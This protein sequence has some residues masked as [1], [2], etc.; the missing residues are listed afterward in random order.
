MCDVSDHI[1]SFTK[2]TNQMAI[3]FAI[4][5]FTI[6][7]FAL[8][9]CYVKSSSATRLRSKSR[10]SVQSHGHLRKASQFLSRATST[11]SKSQS[12]TLARNALL[13]AETAVAFSPNDP[14]PLV[15][16]AF[17]LDLLGRKT[18]A[19]R[20]L[21]SALAYRRGRSLA[22]RE[23]GDVLVKRA[24][25][26]IEVNKKRRV[27]SAIEDLKEALEELSGHGNDSAFCLLGE[28]Y[29]WKGMSEE[30]KWA[31]EEALRVNPE[32]VKARQRL[33][34]LHKQN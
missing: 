29:E 14:A 1:N 31:F 12:L 26:K 7:V 25:L 10:T 32:S 2:N 8:Q 4:L 24:E 18:S 34:I 33:D 28:C 3:Q 19:L 11:S 22:G 9:Y 21:D 15:L 23:R 30:A 20:S 13:E 27:D 16:K 17:A 5:L 6:A